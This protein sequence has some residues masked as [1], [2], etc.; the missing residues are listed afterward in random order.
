[1]QVSSWV[2]V[3][4]WALWRDIWPRSCWIYCDRAGKIY[5]SLRHVIYFVN[6]FLQTA[7]Q[8]RIVFYTVSSIFLLGA[9][10][11]GI[12]ASGEVQPWTFEVQLGHNISREDTHGHINES[13][14]N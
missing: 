11:Y 6:P 10:V 5:C 8:W 12:F 3:T 13:Y 2:L 9:V 1:M 4:V 14:Q 7:E